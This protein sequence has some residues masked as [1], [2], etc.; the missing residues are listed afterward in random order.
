MIYNIA[1]KILYANGYLKESV[2]A[3]KKSNYLSEKDMLYLGII[4]IKLFQRYSLREYLDEAIDILKRLP[5]NEEVLSILNKISGVINIGDYIESDFDKI[6]YLKKQLSNI[7]IF[8]GRADIEKRLEEMENS[9]ILDPLARIQTMV[10]S[11]YKREPFSDKLYDEM[12]KNK[13]FVLGYDPDKFPK[14]V[15]EKLNELGKIEKKLSILKKLSK[16]SSLPTVIEKIKLVHIELK[17]KLKELYYSMLVFA[18]KEEV[19]RIINLI[20][21]AIPYLSDEDIEDIK[22]DML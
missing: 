18:D 15:I 21:I 20:T 4:Y 2:N 12:I 1:A 3:F 14:P 17:N 6:E 13:F 22:R 8:V 5:Q 19:N 9:S 16:T 7:G 10:Y 11:I